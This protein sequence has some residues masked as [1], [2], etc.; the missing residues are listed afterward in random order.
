MSIAAACGSTAFT[1]P[2]GGLGPESMS[3]CGVAGS[4]G[5]NLAYRWS[6]S[7]YVNV[8]GQGSYYSNGVKNW[9]FAGCG[10]SGGGIVPWGNNLAT[11]SFR[12]SGVALTA[13]A[14]P[15]RH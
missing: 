12:A 11:P 14:V 6:H 3:N 2:T 1:N 13:V 8:C 5:F 7:T 4:P 15:W 10:Q 9:T